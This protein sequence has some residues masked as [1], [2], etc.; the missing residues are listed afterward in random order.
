MGVVH[1][2]VSRPVQ[3]Y[4]SESDWTN[5]V[6]YEW[7]GHPCPSYCICCSLL[8]LLCG[9]DGI[10]EV[11]HSNLF[12]ERFISR[13]SSTS[14][15]IVLMIVQKIFTLT[16]YA[17]FMETSRTFSSILENSQKLSCQPDNCLLIFFSFRRW[18]AVGGSSVEF[19]IFAFLLRSALSPSEVKWEANT[20]S[21]LEDHCIPT[22]FSRQPFGSLIACGNSFEDRIE[23]GVWSRIELHSR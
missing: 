13:P 16:L 23:E 6:R 9:P 19:A 8:T 1:S 15:S 2:E 14:I 4:R 20:S 7:R 18:F 22:A 5:V 10:H 21:R 17:Q 3:S 12:T 11:K